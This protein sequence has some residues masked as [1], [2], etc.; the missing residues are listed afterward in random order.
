MMSLEHF[1]LSVTHKVLIMSRLAFMCFVTFPLSVLYETE[2]CIF[3]RRC[4]GKAWGT[5]VF[6]GKEFSGEFQIFAGAKNDWRLV[7]KYEEEQFC[8]LTE[9]DERKPNIV[10]RTAPFPPLLDLLMK[11]TYEARGIKVSKPLKLDLKLSKAVFSSDFV[12]DEKM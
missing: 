11:Q 6:R 7:P 5:K 3:Q 10:P 9:K 2:C 12:Y 1:S 8:R 4:Q